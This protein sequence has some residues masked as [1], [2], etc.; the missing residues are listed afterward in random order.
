[1]ENRMCGIIG[2]IGVPT[3]NVTHAV[4]Q[5][6]KNIEYRGYDS[7]GVAV[8]NGHIERVRKIGIGTKS[9]VMV[10]EEALANINLCGNVAI[11]HTRWATHG[12]VTEANAHPHQSKGV[13]LVHNGIIENHEKLRTELLEAGYTFESET[14][15]EVLAHLVHHYLRD[16]IGL[17]DAVKKTVVRLQGAYA[18]VVCS[19]SNTKRI[20]G[21]RNGAPLLIAH[22][23]GE[24]YLASDAIAIAHKTNQ[25]TYLEDGDIAVV[26]SS[27]SFVIDINNRPMEREQV[28][29]KVKAGDL[30][31]GPYNWFMEKE[32]HEQP[33]AI[34]DTV[35]ETLKYGVS[36]QLFGATAPDLQRVESVRFLA[37]GTSYFASRVAAQWLESIAGIPAAHEVASEYL[38]RKTLHNPR[39]MIVT[40]TQS[41]ETADTLEALKKAKGAGQY[42]TLSICN[43]TE[44]TIPRTSKFVLY[45]RAGV[46]VGVAST[47]AFTTQL[48]AL[49]VFTLTVAKAKGRLTKTQEAQYLQMLRELPGSV[50]N[51]LELEPQ[52]R[53]WAGEIFKKRYIMYLGRNT[54]FSVALEGALKLK[55]ISYIPAEAF[56]A[57][58]LKHGSIALVDQD[59]PIIVVAPNDELFDKIMSSISEVRSRGAVVYV[60]TDEGSTFKSEEGV[61]IIRVPRHASE[62][63]AVMHTVPLQLLAYHTAL[64]LNRNIDKPRNLAKS[65]TVQ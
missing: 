64:L 34:F 62:L 4:L 31:K 35:A 11:G 8:L 40:I 51:A 13:V 21:V 19:L 16:R 7:A 30:D 49:F 52:I 33:K 57:G 15:T 55:E 60:L 46:E 43:V 36:P 20:I 37:C 3:S 47:K 28:T 18:F 56:Q 63:S 45:T 12:K 42:L 9:A 58:E 38:S 5:G 26:E 41:G 14:D 22:G 53:Q 54:H 6:L 1:M 50:K 29:S 48:A 27:N 23:K 39:E 25:V 17:L 44:S 10:L 32:I 24:N 59:V 61:K 65:V 2:A